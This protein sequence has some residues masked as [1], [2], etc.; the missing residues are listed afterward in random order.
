VSDL[1]GTLV[2]TK[3]WDLPTLH[4]IIHQGLLHPKE[5]CTTTCGGYVLGFSGRERNTILFP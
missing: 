5:L 4:S 3:E 2:V 1:D